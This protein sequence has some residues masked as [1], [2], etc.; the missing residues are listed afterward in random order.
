MGF[1]PE[2]EELK[3]QFKL[4]TEKVE[5]QQI[6]TKQ[7]IK[8]VEK[9]KIRKYEFWNRELFSILFFIVC[10]LLIINMYKCRE[11]EQNGILQKFLHCMQYKRFCSVCKDVNA[12]HKVA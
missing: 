6:V 9:K 7:L 5:E 11:M 1:N 3:L 12:M 4:L 10:M 8:E 2:M